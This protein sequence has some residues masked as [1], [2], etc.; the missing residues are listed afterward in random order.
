MNSSRGNRDV[1][2]GCAL[3]VTWS[4]AIDELVEIH[5][6]PGERHE[7]RG[8]DC[9]MVRYRR[10]NDAEAL[11]R[12]LASRSHAAF[13]LGMESDEPLKFIGAWLPSQRKVEKMPDAL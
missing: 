11:E 7:C 10:S 13:L 9:L 12:I 4:F 5:E 6:H 2:G 3:P 8:F 1:I